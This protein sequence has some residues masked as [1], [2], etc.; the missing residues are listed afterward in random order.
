VD[1]V[2]RC[3]T[4]SSGRSERRTKFEATVSSCAT[5]EDVFRTTPR[6]T[7]GASRRPDLFSKSVP[8]ES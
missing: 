5:L 4:V 1:R 6:L 8:A 3:I 2:A 7:Y